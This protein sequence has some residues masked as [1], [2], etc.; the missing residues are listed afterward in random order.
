MMRVH[1]AP[2]LLDFVAADE[3]GSVAIEG[4][5]EQALIGVG[6]FLSAEGVFIVEFEVDRAE[7]ESGV[8]GLGLEF[9]MHALVGLDAD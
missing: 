7:V 3:Q 9:Q 4:V 6:D 8:W 2:G 5:K 1:D